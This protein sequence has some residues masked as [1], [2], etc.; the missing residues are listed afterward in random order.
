MKVSQQF[1]ITRKQQNQPKVSIIIP[2]YNEIEHIGNCVQTIINQDYSFISQILIFDGNSND[3][4]WNVLREFARLDSRIQ[5]YKN[6]LRLQSIA[7]NSGIEK[8]TGDI[9]VRIDAHALYAFNYVSSCVAA[10][11][12]TKASCVGGGVNL[13]S[14][15]RFLPKLIGLVQQH[16]FGTGVARFRRE[17]YE[18]FVDT[19]WP[20]AYRKEV[21]EKIGLFREYLPRTE[22]LDFHARMRQKGLSIFQTPKIKP[23]YHSRETFLSLFMQYFGNGREVIKTIPTNLSAISFRHLV[24]LLA[25]VVFVLGFILAISNTNMKTMLF[26]LIFIYFM[27]ITIASIQIGIKNGLAYSITAP[28]IFITIHLGYSLGS[29]AGLFMLFINFIKSR[30]SLI[31]EERK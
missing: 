17:S 24:P 15:Q 20:G 26:G 27:S 2:T 10:L 13:I 29:W 25:S 4:T 30:L 18:G 3:G 21:F 16:P 23:S 7:L 19:V 9:I 28:I 12:S 6:P 1:T 8:S 5:T 31:F 14:G 11:S 22:D